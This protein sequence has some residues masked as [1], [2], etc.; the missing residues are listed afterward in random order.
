MPLTIDRNR[1]AVLVM[2][3]QNGLVGQRAQL[4]DRA[5]EV[6]AGVRRAGLPV[7]YVAVRFRDGYPEI[8]AR[9][10]TFSS[11]KEQK[12][13]LESDP[14]SDIHP[15]VAPQPGEVVFTKRRIGPFS[16]TDIDVV[17][18][19]RDLTTLVLL[20]YATSGVVLST[21][22]WAVDID[23]SLIVVEDCCDDDDPEV[24]RVLMEK[25]YPRHGEV[26][27][28]KELLAALG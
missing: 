26:V 14:A 28:S 1:T 8:G 19:G 11:V 15:R 22:R 3:Y 12:R 13:L 18:R 16:T 6:L 25:I 23:Y 21:V 5:E 10:K 27:S 2:D 24:H 4:L 7:F 17:L 20:G 9:N